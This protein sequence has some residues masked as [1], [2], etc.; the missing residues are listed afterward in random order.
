LSETAAVYKRAGRTSE[1]EARKS[2]FLAWEPAG[3]A[4]FN[5]LQK[6]LTWG[7]LHDQTKA[8]IIPPEL[9]V[10]TFL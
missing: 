4:G 3:V 1:K 8:L 10:K 7:L 2:V 5:S 6:N 9:F